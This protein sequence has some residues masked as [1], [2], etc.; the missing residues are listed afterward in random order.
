MLH[1]QTTG[2]MMQPAPMDETD[3]MLLC[4]AAYRLLKPPMFGGSGLPSYPLRAA[5]YMLG[6]GASTT[7][8]VTLSTSGKP[9]EQ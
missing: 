9:Q 2:S 7:A 1:K 8:L 6:P 5:M 3:K 4:C